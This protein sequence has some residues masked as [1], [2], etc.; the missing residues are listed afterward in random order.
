[1]TE[2]AEHTHGDIVQSVKIWQRL[3]IGLVLDQLLGSSVKEADVL[4]AQLELKDNNQPAQIVLTGSARNTSSPFSSKIKRSTPW[5]AG[6][7]GL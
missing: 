5:A 6:C 3:S 2:N 1:M 4:L 7:C